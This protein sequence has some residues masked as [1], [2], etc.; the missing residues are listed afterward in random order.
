MC[1]MVTNDAVVK[2][3]EL[4]LGGSHPETSPEEYIVI[5]QYFKQSRKLFEDFA[6]IKIDLNT[7]LTE[8]KKIRYKI[9]QHYDV[10]DTAEQLKQKLILEKLMPK[11]I[12]RVVAHEKAHAERSRKYFTTKFCYYKGDII[13]GFA[14]ITRPKYEEEVRMNG[15]DR[16]EILLAEYYIA[17]IPNLSPSDKKIVEIA[18]KGID[19][20]DKVNHSTL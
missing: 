16:R 18:L 6:F 5:G 17:N 13:D 20:I 7:F 12:K 3:I 2:F 10:F 1:G 9:S 15:W 4:I 8:K 14:A 19:L 11:E